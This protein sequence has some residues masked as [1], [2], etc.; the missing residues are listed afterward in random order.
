MIP[1][2]RDIWSEG[3]AT[4]IGT[5]PKLLDIERVLPDEMSLPHVDSP[6]GKD[7]RSEC[8]AIDLPVAD[9]PVIGGALDKDEVL[10]TEMRWRV[11][12]NKRLDVNDLHDEVRL[13][14][15]SSRYMMWIAVRPLVE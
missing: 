9:D 8:G 12:D 11:A 15:H 5:A 4:S 7:I 10:T 13:G 3:E 2:K 1:C 14:V 6:S